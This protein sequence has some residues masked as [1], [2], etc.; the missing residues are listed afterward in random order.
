MWSRSAKN[1]ETGKFTVMCTDW[2]G[3]LFFTGEFDNMVD[4]D[5]AGE[6]AERRMTFQMQNPAA[7]ALDEIFA[8]MSDDELLSELNT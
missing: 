7:R 3:D 6:D 5:R 8:D 4:A 1:R 2:N